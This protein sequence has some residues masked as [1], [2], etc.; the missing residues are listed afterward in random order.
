MA[1]LLLLCSCKISFRFRLNLKTNAELR[2]AMAVSQ[3]PNDFRVVVKE[4]EDKFLPFHLGH[5][6]YLDEPVSYSTEF[7]TEEISFNLTL[8]PWLCQPVSFIKECFNLVKSIHHSFHLVHS[9]GT[10]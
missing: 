6:V 2:E 7:R 3:K 10:E 4:L 1:C 5:K 8:P 9:F